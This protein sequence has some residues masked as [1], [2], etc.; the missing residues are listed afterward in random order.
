MSLTKED[1]SYSVLPVDVPPKA[2]A[3]PSSGNSNP[4]Q[5]FLDVL[6]API[7][8]ISG[9]VNVVEQAIPKATAGINPISAL[10]TMGSVLIAPKPQTPTTSATKTTAPVS[11]ASAVGTLT[12]ATLN[13]KG[14]VQ[15]GTTEYEYQPSS[16][17]FK[18]Y[19]N[20]S[21]SALV[22]TSDSGYG[23]LNSMYT[24]LT[25]AKTGQSIASAAV[26]AAGQTVTGASSGAQAPQLQ[27]AVD[28]AAVD[29]AQKPAASTTNYL[30]YV[31]IA[32]VVIG[33]GVLL[34]V[35][36]TQLDKHREHMQ[37]M[38]PYMAPVMSSAF[39]ALGE[40]SGGLV[41][42]LGSIAPMMFLA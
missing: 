39:D 30:P 24:S 21:F 15:V 26:A 19:K 1:G 25:Q 18:V 16:K 28:Q 11:K 29:Q 4:L 23:Q 6:S 27:A 33:G 22:T 38:A 31:I 14:R 13:A 37:K 40:S 17:W 7:K 34:Y 10:G 5:G 9:V 2:Q 35:L 42:G 36:W 41:G 12:G 3:N 20:G 32:G 8:A